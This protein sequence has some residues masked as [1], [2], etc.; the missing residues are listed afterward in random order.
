MS[1]RVGTDPVD[2]DEAVDA[3]IRAYAACRVALDAL[4]RLPADVR[5]QAEEPH[6]RFCDAVG[7]PLAAAKPDLFEDER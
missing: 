5:R 1:E 4:P 7:T 2:D 3:L 6:R